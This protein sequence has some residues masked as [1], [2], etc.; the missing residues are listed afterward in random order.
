MTL[1][2][3]A[4]N[5]GPEK[6]PVSFAL[7]LAEVTSVQALATLS[8]LTLAT[9]APL[10]AAALGVGAEAV[11]YQISII[12]GA[13]A[14][15]SAVAGLVV[16]RW[17]AGTVGMAAMLL[18][19]AGCLGLAT[20]LLTVVAL[21]SV[22]IGVGYGLVNPSSSHLLNRYTPPARRN[23]VFSLKQT[24]VPLAGVLAGLLLPGVGQVAGWR[25]A[26]LLVA[27]LF[28]VMLAVFGPGRRL[29]DDDRNPGLPLRGNLMEGPRLVWRAPA[30]RGFALMGFC[31]SA[32]QLSLM[33]FT[34]TMLVHDLGWSIVAAGF[35]V[36]VVQAAGAAGRIGWGLLADRLRSGVAVLA[37]IG[38]LSTAAAF[39][40]ALLGPEWPT[41]A[42]VAVLAV[43]GSAAIGWNGVFLAEVAR[44]APPGTASTAT[45]GAM[46]LTFAGVVVGPALF[47]TLFT[48]TGHYGVTFAAMAVFPVAGAIAVLRAA[49]DRR[50]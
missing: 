7:L 5:A 1:S 11:G 24:G 29:W 16:R 30:L 33:A 9:V 32:I 42:V 36:S 2:Q 12:Y 49:R 21:A 26:A 41:W 34:V 10:A 35:A 3:S 37:G 43:F 48:A 46:M 13:A 15:V 18:G 14:L 45:G 44:V 40:T 27:A 23:L 4:A 31:F 17:G 20:G 19:L 47:A 25:G 8:V 38:L 22:L 39:V 28:V 6:P 50:R